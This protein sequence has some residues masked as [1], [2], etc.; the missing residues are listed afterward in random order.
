MKAKTDD[1]PERIASLTQKLK[2]AEK[3]VADLR[4]AQLRNQAATLLAEADEVNGVT[5]VAHRLTEHV[6]SNDVRALA[7][8]LKSRL[9][10]KPAVI[11]LIAE[12][13]TGKT[14]FVVA[15]TKAGVAQG[16]KLMSWPRC[17]VATSKVMVA[18][19]QIWLKDLRETLQALNLAS[20]LLKMKS[21]A[22]RS[23][24]YIT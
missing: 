4:A 11:A 1:V 24:T 5:V 22:S 19:N 18:V 20:R 21:A 2:E 15:A 17:S 16:M 7:I 8:D 3:A 6:S 12:D 14:P 13:G 9:G 23:T 10:E